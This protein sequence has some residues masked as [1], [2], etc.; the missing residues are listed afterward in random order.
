MFINNGSEELDIFTKAEQLRL[1]YNYLYSI[2][3][4]D[5][6]M[7][8]Y[9]QKEVVNNINL[10][11]FLKDI[12]PLH[13]KFK[14]SY[15][16]LDQIE[17]YFGENISIYFEFMN[18]YQSYLVIPSFFAI[19]FYII[20]S[21]T[22]NQFHKA[23]YNEISNLSVGYSFIIMIWTIIFMLNWRRKEQE[24]QVKW[25]QFKYV[26]YKKGVLGKQMNRNL[27]RNKFFK[28]KEKLNLIT[29]EQ[30]VKYSKKKRYLQYIIS[31]LEAL[32]TLII[33]ALIKLVLFNINGII[34]NP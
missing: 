30:Y 6:G 22:D 19:L 26:I 31:A 14:V 27:E 2:K 10:Q 7:L 16:S 32:P 23:S 4:K 17:Q 29:G 21:Q 15:K 34:K 28:G 5:V 8:T 9:L 13:S 18:F 20:E 33:A 12:V 1:I 11:G 24:L 3:I 25:V